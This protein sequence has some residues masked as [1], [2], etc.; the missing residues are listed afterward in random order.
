MAPKTLSKHTRLHAVDPQERIR[1]AVIS[2]RI[3]VLPKLK[4]TMDVDC[5]EVDGGNKVNVSIVW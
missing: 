5:G 2:E 1:Y 3:S 4:I